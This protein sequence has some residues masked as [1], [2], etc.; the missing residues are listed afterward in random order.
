MFSLRFYYV[1]YFT[2]I[3]ASSTLTDDD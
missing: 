2:R 3:V 1:H